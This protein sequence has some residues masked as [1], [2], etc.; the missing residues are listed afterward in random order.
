LIS[1][2][3]GRPEDA[4]YSIEYIRTFGP[5]VPTLGVCLGHQAIAVAFGGTVDLAPE[6]R[7][8]KV[9]P[10]THDGRGIFRDIPNPF[11][12]T[13]YHSLA[14]VELPVELQVSAHSEDGV[15][16]G[17]RH[18]EFP[19]TGVQ[20]HPESIMTKSGMNLLANFLA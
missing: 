2:G 3:P 15:V 18:R 16:Q 20:F 12:A 7:H 9:S 8:G 11:E 14:T 4:G 19:I 6:P 1:P 10:I 5:T 13:R 17:I